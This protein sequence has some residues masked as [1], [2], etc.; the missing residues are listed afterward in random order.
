MPLL[1]LDDVHFA[2]PGHPSVLQ[3][4][5][6]ALM[7]GDRI[8]ITGANGAGKSTLLKLAVGLVRPAAGRVF[9]FGS[10]RRAEADFYEVRRRA[11]LVFQDADD[12]L[13][14]PTVLEDVAFGPLNL[15]KTPNEVRDIVEQT[16]RDLGLLH[17]RDRV[18][19][20]LSG[21]EKRLVSVATVLAMAPDVLLLD[22]PSTGLDEPTTER[23]IAIL[24]ALPQSLLIVSHDAHFRR[25]V[26]MSELRLEQGRLIDHEPRCPHA[27]APGARTAAE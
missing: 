10:E 2:Y 13:F 3:G 11:G 15:G 24:N 22:E 19:H 17:L 26:A 9:A 18:T 4:V 23:L 21:G 27:L 1:E 25:K 14:C 7:P 5:A 8:A 16:L 6:L 12:Q 20:K